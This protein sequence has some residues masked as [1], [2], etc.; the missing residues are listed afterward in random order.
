MPEESA[1]NDLA[2]RDGRQQKR[3]VQ[4]APGVLR[5]HAEVGVGQSG[6]GD[7]RD[8]D[9]DTEDDLREGAVDHG[10]DRADQGVEFDAEAAE[11]TLHDNAAQRRQ[12][13]PADFA[14]GVDEQS[15]DREDDEQ[16]ADD[17]AGEAVR[18]FDEEAGAGFAPVDQEQMPGVSRPN[19]VGH[20]DAERR[21]HRPEREQ[22]H[23]RHDRQDGPAVKQAVCQ[24]RFDWGHDNDSITLI[25]ARH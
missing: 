11:Q 19:R 3:Q 6:R 16:D 15:P 24:R 8:G 18:V 10:E 9:H 14:A 20:A 4:P 12:S 25:P 13:E 23:G 17:I 22:A 5:A 7:D 2:E 21:D 1:P